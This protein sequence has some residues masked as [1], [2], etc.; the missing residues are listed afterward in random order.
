MSFLTP[1][2][3]EVAALALSVGAPD[4]GALVTFVGA[5]RDHHAGR[6]VVSLAYTAY[7]PMAEQVCGELINEA[8]ARWNVRVAM[9]HRLG[10]L[11]IGDPAVAVVVAAAHRSAAFDAC[12]WLIDGLKSRVPIWKRERYADGTEAWVDPTAPGGVT[13]STG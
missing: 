3:I 6:K 2:P 13:V 5:V 12:R 10:E 9:V 7:G 1:Q 4:R 11:S 8:E